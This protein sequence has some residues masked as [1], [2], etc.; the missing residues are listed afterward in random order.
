MAKKR[1]IRTRGFHHVRH[2][3]ATLLLN[4]GGVPLPVVSKILGHKSPKITLEI[5]AH[6]MTADIGRHRNAFDQVLK[7]G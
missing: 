6:V 4:S 5:Y 2:T 1:N 3:A 7:I